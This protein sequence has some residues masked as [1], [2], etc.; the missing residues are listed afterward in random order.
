MDAGQLHPVDGRPPLLSAHMLT[1]FLFRKLTQSVRA[2][3]DAPFRRIQDISRMRPRLITDAILDEFCSL[4]GAHCTFVKRWDHPI[5]K[6][7]ILR[8]FGKKAAARTAEQQLLGCMRR[9]HGSVMLFSRAIDSES[10]LEGNWIDATAATAKALSQKIKVPEELAFYPQAQYE[11]TFNKEGHFS[12]SQLAVLAKMPTRQEV[13]AMEPV[14]V[15]VAPEGC[16]SVPPGLTTQEEFLNSGFTQQQV[17]IGPER[18]ENI[19]LGLQAKR[20]QYG[21]RHRIASTIHAAMGQDLCTVITKV[22]AT[23]EDYK[24]WEK[25]Q[26][27][28]LLSRTHFAKDIIFVGSKRSTTEALA[29]LLLKRSQF[30]D[31]MDYLLG[32][33]APDTAAAGAE[34]SA[35]PDHNGGAA[36]DGAPDHPPTAERSVAAPFAIDIVRHHPFRPIDV[37]LPQDNSGF[38]Y[39]LVSTKEPATTYIG[40]AKNLAARLNTHNRG[41]GPSATTDP[42]L[43]PWAI[44]AYVCGFEGCP[45]PGRRYF[46]SL[47]QAAREHRYNAGHSIDPDDIASLASN[48]VSTQVY[49]ACFTLQGKS[50][51]FVRCGRVSAFSHRA[52][53][54][55]PPVVP[56]GT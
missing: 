3:H 6:P 14:T 48:L 56:P 17:G 44:L 35:G 51:V 54:E 52:H 4:I 55:D 34:D 10:T 21:L 53:R 5:I 50:L 49:K 28:V 45:E 25:E 26:V 1:C 19:G 18:A 32:K 33:L 13:E 8:M 30:S 23:E 40:Q 22:N 37:Q 16:K 15:Y 31:Y 42:R 47:W 24:L 39:I 2:C 43:R 41:A 12:Q 11:I 36:A 7:S 27:V 29:N 20:K 38:V 9:M 46:E